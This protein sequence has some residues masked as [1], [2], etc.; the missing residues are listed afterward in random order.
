VYRNEAFLPDVL[1]VVQD[2]GSRL[3]GTLEAV[4][5]VDGSP[6]GCERWLLEHLPHCAVPSQLIV[7]SRNFGSF[8]AIRAGLA[9]A[10]GDHAAVMAADL[11]EPPSLILDFFRALGEGHDVAIGTRASRADP[12]AGQLSSQLFWRVFRAL[13]QPDMPANGVDMFA[14]SRAARDALLQLNEAHSS[15]VAQLFWIGFPRVEVPYQRLPRRH[16]ASGWTFRRKVKYL[17]DSIFSFTDIPIRLLTAIGLVGTVTFL[18]AGIALMVARF[19][20]AVPVPG[21]TA[22]M[23]TILFSASLVLLALGIVGNYVWRAYENTKQRPLA[24]VQARK[25]FPGSGHG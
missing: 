2:L 14:V 12:W 6:D 3:D 13:V 11:Q 22:I 15:L 18:I 10:R 20:Q 19:V 4:F 1:G 24:I 8:T 17:L 7:L 5:V 23:V 16:G 25:T 9:A 21:Y